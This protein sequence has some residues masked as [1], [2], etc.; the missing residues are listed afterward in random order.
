MTI[1]KELLQ[2]I[3]S[4][5][6]SCPFETGGILGS[7]DGILVSEIIMDPNDRE[8]YRCCYI[9]NIRYF[10]QCI[11]EWNRKNIVFMGMFHTHFHNV[12]T[13]SDGDIKY[14]HTIMSAMPNE[15]DR[16]FFPI[17]ILPQNQMICYEAIREKNNISV[18]NDVLKIV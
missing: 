9:P 3:R 8:T 4:N 2:T 13:L 11:E 12:S 6:S 17:Y 7:R 5:V 10:N 18:K 14:I 1:V 16:L 15:I